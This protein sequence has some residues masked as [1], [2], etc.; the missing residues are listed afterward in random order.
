MFMELEL[1]FLKKKIMETYMLIAL[2]NVHV[3]VL[4]GQGESMC[5]NGVN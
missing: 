1:N 5:H 4:C 3:P 2:L